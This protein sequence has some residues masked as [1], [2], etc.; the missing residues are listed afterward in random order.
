MGVSIDR[1]P[2]T[3]RHRRLVDTGEEELRS[4]KLMHGVS[5]KKRGMQRQ[6][7]LKSIIGRASFEII[8]SQTVLLPFQYLSAL[9]FYFFILFHIHQYRAESSTDINESYVNSRLVT[10]LRLAVYKR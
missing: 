3:E 7:R 10:T 1:R 2:R 6:I 4:V 9:F 8:Q 5:I